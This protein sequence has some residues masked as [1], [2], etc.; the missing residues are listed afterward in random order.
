VSVSD[1]VLRIV[2]R[3]LTENHR[4]TPSRDRQVA[5]Y[6]KKLKKAA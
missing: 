2:Y 6:Y 3:M 5:T 1:K 4:Y